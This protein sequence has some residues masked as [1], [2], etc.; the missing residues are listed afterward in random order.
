MTVRAV[1]PDTARVVDAELLRRSLRYRLRVPR[2]PY[3]VIG[4]AASLRNA[5]AFA[6][7]SRTV[8]LRS[9]RH[10]SVSPRMRRIRRPRRSSVLPA[11]ART[12]GA[13]DAIGV[14]PKILVLGLDGAPG[15]VSIDA[16]IITGLLSKPC[17]NGQKLTVVEIRHRKELLEEIERSQRESSDTETR[18]RNR[19]IDAQ[20]MV[21][22][23]GRVSGGTFSIQLE[24]TRVGS[25][26]SEASAMVSGRAEDAIKL[27]ER[28]ADQLREQL[29]GP[30]SA[31]R[32]SVSG[33][34][35][36]AEVTETW[37][38]GTV[39]YEL[40]PLFEGAP[41]YQLTGGT[42]AW[43]LNGSV[44]PNCSISASATLSLGGAPD[45]YD[46][47]QGPSGQISLFEG[48]YTVTGSYDKQVP[49]SNSCEPDAKFKPYA[50][51]V[52]SGQ[53]RPVGSGGELSGSRTDRDVTWTWSLQPVR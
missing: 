40:D 28:A 10:R 7:V 47:L 46:M 24:A 12:A 51:F 30:P 11:R 25:G 18:L 33:T 38:S 4:S 31:F 2:G 1:R 3:V 42:M 20:I 41:I 19:L 23:G 35:R 53:Q 14:D 37:S 13:S 52:D 29:C 6:A 48:S 15:G 50:P 27:I 39:S 8:L 22:G 34:R 45:G 44:S 36:T 5:R 32:G 9:G 17:P 26:Q 49:G 43:E 16:V 21:R